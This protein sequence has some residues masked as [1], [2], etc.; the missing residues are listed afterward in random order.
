MFLD[1]DRWNLLSNYSLPP[2]SM[3][4][5]TKLEHFVRLTTSPLC[6]WCCPVLLRANMFGSTTRLQILGRRIV[7]GFQV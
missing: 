4:P 1:L 5:D 6:L 2:S 3:L 7:G